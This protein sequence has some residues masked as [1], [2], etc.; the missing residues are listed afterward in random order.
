M[1][2]KKSDESSSSSTIYEK[3]M[4]YSPPTPS[5][6]DPESVDSMLAAE[7]FSLSFQDRNK[8][9]EEM[10]GVLCLTPEETP[11]LVQESLEKLEQEINLLPMEEKETL[12]LCRKRF[13]WRGSDQKG[14]SYTNDVDF[15]IRFLRCTLF[16]VPKAAKKIAN[17]LDSVVVLFGES[18][19]QRPIK[20]SDFT[21]EELQIFRTGNLQLLPFRDRSGRRI[22]AGVD[23]LAIQYDSKLRYKMLYYLLWTAADDVETQLKGIV[24]IIW[25]VSDITQHL[26]NKDDMMKLQKKILKGSPVRVCAF[27]FCVPDSPI[28]HLLRTIFTLTLDRDK[29][30][31]LKFHVGQRTELQYSVGGYGIPVDHIP[32]TETGNVKTQNLRLWLNLRNIKENGEEM[33]QNIIECPGSNDV[34]FRPSKLI[35][36][37]PGNVKFQSLIERCHER[38]MGVTAASREIVSEIQEDGGRVLI[39]NKRGWWTNSTDQAQKQFKVSV[40]YRDYKKKNKAKMQIHNSSTFVFHDQDNRKRKR[41]EDLRNGGGS[42]SPKSACTFFNSGSSLHEAVLIDTS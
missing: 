3:G 12:M 20:L 4:A 34:L 38:G 41:P 30:S 2:D 14:G 21:E 37:H 29:R 18:A 31:R 35:K 28:F 26:H 22:V 16:D 6:V 24:V 33:A 40:S 23:G 27:H 42:S 5:N 9:S 17:Y 25:P 19:L 7:M 1:I 15:R 36:G 39:W 11:K 13:G 32:L 8:I 10:H